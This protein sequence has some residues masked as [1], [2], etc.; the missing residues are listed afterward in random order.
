[1]APKRSPKWPPNWSPKW[2][3]TPPPDG[4]SGAGP[5]FAQKALEKNTKKYS[6]VQ[7]VHVF[8]ENGLRDFSFFFVFLSRWRR[9]SDLKKKRYNYAFPVFLKTREMP[10]RADFFFLGDVFMTHQMS[11]QFFFK[12]SCAGS[13]CIFLYFFQSPSART[14]PSEAGGGRGW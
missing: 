10:R 4:V 13:R 9:A 8:Y 7:L 1:M 3:P 5:R 11:N 14:V 12:T 6:S 2:S